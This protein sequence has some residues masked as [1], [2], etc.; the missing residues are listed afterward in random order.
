MVVDALV[1]EWQFIADKHLKVIDLRSTNP[2]RE[3]T[4]MKPGGTFDEEVLAEAVAVLINAL[5]TRAL[6]VDFDSLEQGETPAQLEERLTAS[7][8]HALQVEFANL[9]FIGIGNP[10]LLT[11]DMPNNTHQF[12]P[13]SKSRHCAGCGADYCQSHPLNRCVKCNHVL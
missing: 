6:A 5:K 2:V 8:T 1:I 13:N 11:C 4:T 3:G 12:K 9:G 10:I 7:V